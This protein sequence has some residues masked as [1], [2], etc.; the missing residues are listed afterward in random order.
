MPPTYESFLS[1]YSFLPFDACEISFFGWDS[2]FEVDHEMI[3][4]AERDMS[5]QLVAAGYV[6]IGR[7]DTG[8]Y[9]P[10]CFDLNSQA[11]NREYRIVQVDH[12]WVLQWSRIK[13][14]REM[15][16]SFRKMI[17]HHLPLS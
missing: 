17:E 9:D 4:L 16:P 8:S 10:I 11:Q 1:R 7:P 6:Q 15:W 2:K 12:E 14:L 3:P 5:K 13:I